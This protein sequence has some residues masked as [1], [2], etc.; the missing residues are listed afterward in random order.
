MR[1]DFRRL[2]ADDLP[3]MHKW[4]QHEHV[5][6]WWSER[7]TYAQVADHYLPAI[8]GRRPTDLY[9]IVVGQQPVGFIQTYKV[10]DYPEHRELVQVEKGVAGV[11]LFISEPELV[12]RGLGTEVLRQ[13]VDEIVF[14]DEAVHACVADPD[15][16]NVSSLRAFEKAGFGRVREFVDPTD[17]RQHVLMRRDR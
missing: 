3:L 12:G 15:V 7:R 6:R 8:E 4:L 1:I 5:R 10:A 13:F 2:L 17:A 14:S 11:D 16:A 9:L